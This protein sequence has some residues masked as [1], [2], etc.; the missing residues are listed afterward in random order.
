MITANGVIRETKL[1]PNALTIMCE[2]TIG[3]QIGTAPFQLEN[4]TE[5]LRKILA[6]TGSL[7]WEHVSDS[8][9]RVHIIE[10]NGNYR[11]GGVGHFLNDEWYDMPWAV[12]EKEEN[13]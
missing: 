13:E 5:N 9:I 2:T 4:S 10:D 3:N 12:E 8:P 7:C 6:I 1:T 11:L